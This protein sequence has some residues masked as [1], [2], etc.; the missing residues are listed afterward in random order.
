MPQA[1]KIPDAKAAVDKEWEKLA[2]LPAWQLNKVKGKKE[3]I[4][5]AQREKNEVHFAAFM[6]ISHLKN[7][8]L[9]PKYQKYKGGV[10]LRGDTVKDDSGASQ[11]TVAKVMDV[12]ARQ[13][14]G[15]GQA[16]DAVS[17]YAQV[18]MEDAPQIVQS[19]EVRMSVNMWIRPSRHKWPMSW[20]IVEDPVV[21]RGRNLYGHPIA[22]LLWERQFEKVPSKL[23]WGKVT[24]WECLYGHRKQ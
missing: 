9:E 1:M 12:M 10:G 6:D 2:K 18:R 16:A 8:E 22:G 23:G 20:S 11:T 13:H 24:N 3:V 4:L 14:D 5:E 17:A 7:A 19:P 21:L 15:V